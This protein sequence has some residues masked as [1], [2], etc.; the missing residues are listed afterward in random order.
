MKNVRKVIV[1]VLLLLI[2]FIVGTNKNKNRI[3]ST[4]D[5][6]IATTT[7]NVRTGAST[8]Y[9]ISFTLQE[10]DEV[11][12]LLKMG[13]WYKIKYFEKTGYVYSKYLKHSRTTAN[14]KTTANVDFQMFQQVVLY[15]IIGVFAVIIL[16]VGFI[17]FRKIRNKKLLKTVTKSNRGT[18]SERDLVLKLLKHKIPPQ[19]IFHDLY[20][21]KDND[22]FTQIDLAVITQVG[23]IVFE[24]KDYSGWI[25]GN[26]NQS[27]WT[28]VL[29]H[30]KQKY[31]FYN[32][33]MQNNSHIEDLRKQINQF[34][35]VPFYSIVVF[36]GDSVLK[37]INFVPK[38]TLIVK[39]DRVL[40][41]MGIIMKNDPV[42][43]TNINE[44]VKILK[45]A[46]KNG[47]DT[48]TQIQHIENVRDMLGKNRIFE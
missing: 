41:V 24:V 36:Y 4:T 48:E 26:G 32:P 44:I 1:I 9:S 2:W 46:V 38:G 40:E 45:E 14:T 7:L 6:C 18:R 16:N 20:L 29:A 22:G 27:Q 25:Y 8:E 11:E 19:T 43:Y 34:E 17:I 39:S 28:Q 35:N 15:I 31:R 47:E 23:I 3:S 30:G 12:V 37:N 5:Y 13:D 21:R 33:I 10:G 42:Q